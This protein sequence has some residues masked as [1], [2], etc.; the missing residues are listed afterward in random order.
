MAI[1]IALLILSLI[2]L[3]VPIVN[4]MGLVESNIAERTSEIGIRKA[5]GANRKSLIQ[6]FLYENMFS[7]A[8]GAI[9]GLI[10]SIFTVVYLGELLLVF[11]DETNRELYFFSFS[12]LFDIRV[13]VLAMFFCFIFNIMSVYIP[14]VRATRTSIA[15]AV[16][17]GEL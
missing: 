8:I 1:Q 3:S 9:I 7:T 6:Q 15:E 2:L 16:K 13:F 14:A 10:C 5:Y 4:G 11:S 17:G 12:S